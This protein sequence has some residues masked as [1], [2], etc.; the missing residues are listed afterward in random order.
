M[1]RVSSA[2]FKAKRFFSSFVFARLKSN[3][4]QKKLLLVVMHNLMHW[5]CGFFI[6]RDG[7]AERL[8]VARLGE[9][10]HT[11]RDLLS[12]LNGRSVEIKNK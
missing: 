4:C 8:R 6:S 3:Y 11:L 2:Q 9:D 7:S 10:K 5:Y 1:V 12:L